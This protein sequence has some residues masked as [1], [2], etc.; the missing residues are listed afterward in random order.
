ML[1]ACLRSTS[2]R[3][4]APN[5]F[6]LIITSLIGLGMLSG[7]AST[8]PMEQ[9]YFYEYHDGNRFVRLEPG[10]TA[11]EENDHPY[12]IQAQELQTRLRALR[13]TGTITFGNDTEVFT[14]DEANNLA[15]R[16]S[17]ALN[18]AGPDQDITFQS[19]GSR[20][21]FG[22]NSPPSFTTGRVFIQ[23]GRLH[24]ILGVLHSLSD[25]DQLIFGDE[26]FPI[27][28]RNARVESVWDIEPGEDHAIE[29]NRSD[30]ISF[31]LVPPT[32]ASQPAAAAIVTTPAQSQ[33]APDSADNTVEQRL[34]DIESR[35]RV[36]DELKRKNLITDQEYS[37]KRSAI[38]EGL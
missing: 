4:I 16:L 22:K 18:R 32:P 33:A 23:D 25:T 17:S 30:W 29:N 24:L 14:A 35:L 9:N 37:D 34:N 12:R 15:N 19:A 20:G 28:S 10:E 21:V 26:L 11:T 1:P 27:G 13:A 38:L 36:L 2:C 3:Q 8:T 7:C 6:A 5:W 31:A